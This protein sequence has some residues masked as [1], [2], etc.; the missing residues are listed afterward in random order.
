MFKTRVK[1]N[2]R[3]YL[4]LPEDKRYEIIEGELAMVPSPGWSH[5]TISMKIF[6]ILAQYV[7]ST[8][9]GEVRYAPIDVIFSEE[10]VLQPDILYIAKERSGII[11]ERGVEGAPDLVVE[12]LSH[13]TRQKDKGIKRKIY[14]KYGVKEYW[15]V[16]SEN[17][18]IEVSSLGKKGLETTQV[19]P[20]GSTFSS[21]L[22]KGFS[23]SV[24]N[25]F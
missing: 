22:L 4:S 5:Q 14:A 23:F 11:E 3:D 21:P 9:I 24:K 20:E 17:R 19:Y 16:D 12:I 18:T 13:A 1:F 2:Y 15:I 6:Q 7:A 10:N 25:I 8:N